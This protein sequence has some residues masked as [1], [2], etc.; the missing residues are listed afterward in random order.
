MSEVTASKQL[1]IEPGNPHKI[2]EILQRIGRGA[3]GTV[4]LVK[5][6]ETGELF[7][8]KELFRGHPDDEDGEIKQIAREIA[9]LQSCKHDNVVRYCGTY[10][11]PSGSLWVTME[12]CKGGSVED[13][14]KTTDRPLTEKQISFVCCQVLHGLVYLH[15]RH[16]IHRDIKAGNV[17]VTSDGSI[18]LADFGVAARLT[19]TMSRRNTFIGT[20]FWMAPEAIQQSDYDERADIWSLGITAIEMAELAAPHA[21]ENPAK[22]LFNIPKDPPPTLQAKNQWSPEFHAFLERCLIKDPKE[23]PTAEQLLQDPFVRSVSAEDGAAIMSALVKEKQAIKD[24]IRRADNH[25]RKAS[26]DADD[27]SKSGMNDGGDSDDTFID[28]FDDANRCDQLD[29]D[30][31][32]NDDDTQRLLTDDMSSSPSQDGRPSVAAIPACI[33]DGTVINLPLINVDEIS[34]E[35]VTSVLAGADG[36]SKR[37]QSS[38]SRWR[39][40]DVVEILDGRRDDVDQLCAARLHTIDALLSLYRHYNEGIYTDTTAVSAERGD[41]ARKMVQK[42]GSILK[43]ILRV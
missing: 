10:Q 16:T 40:E 6:R 9:I 20:M 23:R 3:Y 28:G 39:N 8:V 25:R 17:L 4:Y 7:A 13:I 24:E 43:T 27:P 42:Y 37:E 19:H 14:F 32:A 30:G 18:K 2:F 31:D 36:Q 21:N 5:H 35:D 12:Y 11:D 1:P 15:S 29:N 34:L 26:A 33:A 22:A 38:L 41:H